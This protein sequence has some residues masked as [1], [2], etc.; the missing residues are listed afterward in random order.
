MATLLRDAYRELRRRR[1]EEVVN[2]VAR[3]LVYADDA[4]LIGSNPE[5]IQD[6][7]R[8]VES[9]GAHYGL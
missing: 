4:L 8:C 1:G 9:C 3:D 7:M 5:V 2:G 6:F